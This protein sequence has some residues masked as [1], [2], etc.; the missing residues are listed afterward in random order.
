MNTAKQQRQSRG[1]SESV[2]ASESL[3]ITTETLAGGRKPEGRCLRSKEK[4]LIKAW[5][6]GQAGRSAT[7]GPGGFKS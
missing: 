2:L 1:R 7:V 6:K 3:P 4:V 5:A